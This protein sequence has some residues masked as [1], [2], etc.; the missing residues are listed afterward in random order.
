M[1]EKKKKVVQQIKNLLTPIVP[2]GTRVILFGSQA[3][4]DARPDSDWDVLII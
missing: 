1:E 4:G 3:R 2:Q